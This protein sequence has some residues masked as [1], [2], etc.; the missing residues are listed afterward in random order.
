MNA[1][2]NLRL[3]GSS[4]AIGKGNTSF[5]PL[6]AVGILNVRGLFTP[7]VTAPG[8]DAGAY[9]SGNVGNQQ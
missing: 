5:A 2:S 4:P 3:Q 7:T 8:A 1:T 6:H 9:Q